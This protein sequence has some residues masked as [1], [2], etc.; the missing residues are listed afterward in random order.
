VAE[1]RNYLQKLQGECEVYEHAV[2][3]LEKEKADRND[4]LKDI[5]VL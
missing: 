1:E 3:E 2:E 5:Q 4:N